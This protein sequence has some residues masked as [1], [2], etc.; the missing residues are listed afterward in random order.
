[1]ISAILL[2]AGESRRMGE[3]NKLLLPFGDS[4]L[5][6]H[7]ADQLLAST[8]EEVI[9]VVGH[10]AEAVRTALGDKPLRCVENPDYAQGMTTSIHAGVRAAA[11]QAVGLM[12]CLSDLPFV[13]ADEY[14][15]LIAAF[16]AKLAEAADAIVR[17]VHNGQVG[18]PVL[19]AA[20]YREA[21]LTHGKMEG[22]RGLIKQHSEKVHQI[23]MSTD[24]VLRDIDTPEEYE[25][26]VATHV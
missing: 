9:A 1:V 3:R 2:A 17:P 10:E 6:A 23:P 24:H 18:N 19:F 14:A 21:L 13:T 7:I 4:C 22:C 20:S 25:R 16:R 8:A 5:I 11:P 26:L 15:Q 12:I